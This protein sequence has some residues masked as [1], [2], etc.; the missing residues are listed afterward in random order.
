MPTCQELQSVDLA[1]HGLGMSPEAPLEVLACSAERRIYPAGVVCHTLTSGLPAGSICAIAP[2]LGI[3][4]PELL[5]LQMAPRLTFAQLV[6]LGMELCGSYG[7]V[8]GSSDGFER[9]LAVTS[10]GRM[11][12]FLVLCDGMHGVVRAR[13]ALPWVIEGSRS[14]METTLTLL[15]TLGRRRGGARLPVPT[16]SRCARSEDSCHAASS[17]ER[18]DIDLAWREQGLAVVFD[19]DLE[20]SVDTRCEHGAERAKDLR[21]MGWKVV[22]VAP[23]QV[24][25]DEKLSLLNRQIAR[26]LGRR[27]PRFDEGFVMRRAALRDELMAVGA[28]GGVGAAR[29]STSLTSPE[30][31]LEVPGPHAS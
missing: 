29:M 4:S 22:V 31:L 15:L 21:A 14:P 2:K 16:L 8:P 7:L 23:D 6:A 20:H 13:E 10:V 11:S 5:F 1:K 30:A 19:G 24:T 3:V 17:Q 26:L 28:T 9:R 25:D 12:A 27:R 18:H